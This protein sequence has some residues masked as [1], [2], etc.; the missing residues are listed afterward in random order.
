MSTPNP[1]DKQDARAPEAIPTPRG[2]RDWPEDFAHENGQ[3]LG[4]CEVCGH[5][6]YGHKRRLT[7]KLCAKPVS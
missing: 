1:T 5:H 4:W 6:F 7:C 3:Y 2:W